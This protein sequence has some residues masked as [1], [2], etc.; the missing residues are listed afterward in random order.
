MKNKAS[1]DAIQMPDNKSAFQIISVEELD[2]MSPRTVIVNSHE[3]VFQGVRME[4]D[5]YTT[6]KTFGRRI[7][8]DELTLDYLLIVYKPSGN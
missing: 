1:S 5:T 2:Q 6:W 7:L 8:S 4:G 3:K